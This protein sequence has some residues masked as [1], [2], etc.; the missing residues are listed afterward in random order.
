MEI[1]GPSYCKH[2]AT[3]TVDWSNDN[4]ETKCSHCG[5]VVFL[6]YEICEHNGINPNCRIKAMTLIKSG[7]GAAPGRFCWPCSE[8]MVNLDW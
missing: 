6:N 5:N 2:C 7:E 4:P 3:Y 1:S 8:K